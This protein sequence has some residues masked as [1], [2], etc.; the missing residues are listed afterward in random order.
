MMSFEHLKCL[1]SHVV[2]RREIN[3]IAR[4]GQGTKDLAEKS[5]AKSHMW[6]HHWMQGWPSQFFG[7][8]YKRI[9]MSIFTN[10][11]WGQP[12]DLSNR[13]NMVHEFKFP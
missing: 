2:F 8:E 9:R 3:F 1:G 13:V 7:N 6:Q 5:E 4:A 12:T 10:L 11:R